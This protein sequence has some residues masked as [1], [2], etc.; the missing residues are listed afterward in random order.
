[1]LQ[2][3]RKIHRWFGSISAIFMLFIG[4]TGLV[5]Q[6][7]LW[8]V[9]KAPPGRSNGPPPVYD[10]LAVDNTEAINLLA[11]AMDAA[12]AE[13]P[14]AEVGNIAVNLK[15]GR[16]SFTGDNL[17][18]QRA[19]SFDGNTGKYFAPK[20]KSTGLRGFYEQD[21]HYI[22]QD[23]HAGYYFGF[24]GRLISCLMAISLIVLSITGLQVYLDMYTR[25][26]KQGRKG[27]FW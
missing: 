1:M 21:W 4:I 17:D 13:F 12:R 27:L 9:G 7:E 2:L 18:N 26:K 15:N 10:A 24:L 11:T 3:F 6:L 19:T 5:L 14:N 22:M 23:L 8:I 25:R 20:P 16:V